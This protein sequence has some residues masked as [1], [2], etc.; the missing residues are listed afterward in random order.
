M[1]GV[2]RI[3]TK[4]DTH[5]HFRGMLICQSHVNPGLDHG[6]NN[7]PAKASYHTRM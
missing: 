5:H 1:V 3:T 2:M 4:R 7:C 6:F